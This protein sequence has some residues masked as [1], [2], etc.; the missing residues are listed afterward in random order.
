MIVSALAELEAVIELKA[1]FL[2]GD[3]TRVQWRKL[4]AHLHLLRDEEP[5]VFKSLPGSLWEIAFRQHRNSVSAY[6][7]TLDRLHLAAVEHFGLTRLMTHDDVQ[8]KAA[9]ALR[10]EV[11]SPGR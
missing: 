2:A 3:Y 11:I 4:E 7:R 8:A 5:F 9:A 6:C 10:L 1:A